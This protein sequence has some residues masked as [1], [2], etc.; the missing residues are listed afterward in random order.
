MQSETVGIGGLASCTLTV[1][2]HSCQTKTLAAADVDPY[3]PGERASGVTEEAFMAGD[4]L[5]CENNGSGRIY[6]YFDGFV[7]LTN[8]MAQADPDTVLALANTAERYAVIRPSAAFPTVSVSEGMTDPASLGA[9]GKA[10]LVTAQN[11]LLRGER[12]QYDDSRL[13][14]ISGAEFRWKKGA[15]APENYTT[16]E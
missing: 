3:F 7:E 13:S 10:L 1:T 2:N 6:L 16:D 15:V 8:G 11:Y 5:L 14:S 9:A 12:I 4:V